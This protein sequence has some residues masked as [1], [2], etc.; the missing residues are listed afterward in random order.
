MSEVVV[1]KQ[2]DLANRK[3]TDEEQVEMDRRIAEESGI[4]EGD[5]NL[6]LWDEERESAAKQGKETEEEE[7]P[8]G[9]PETPPEGEETEEEEESTEE[10][11]EEEEVKVSEE[12]TESSLSDKEALIKEREEALESIEDEAEKETAQAE[13][14][15]MKKVYDKEDE[16]YEET[17]KGEQDDLQALMKEHEIG[18]DDAQTIIDGEKAIVEKYSGDPKKMARAFRHI[19]SQYSRTK[20]IAEDA[21]MRN[22]Q[23]LLDGKLEIDPVQLVKNA[24]G[25]DVT[26]EDLVG[27]Y[28]EQYPKMTV[29]MEDDAVFELIHKDMRSEVKRIAQDKKRQRKETALRKRETLIRSIPRSARKYDKQIKSILDNCSDGQVARDTFN[30]DDIILNCKGTDFD[31]AVKEAEEK[32][33]KRGLENR[34]IV[35][36]K[37]SPTGGKKPAS[38][39]SKSSGLS[40]SEKKEAEKMYE[41]DDIPVKDKYKHYKD[42]L[43]HRKKFDETNK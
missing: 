3:P 37:G 38:K 23:A 19:Q 2:A 30:L 5:P 6:P 28:R 35:A 43:D 41:T 33:Y 10:E 4:R 29:D 9:E 20:A 13:L 14:D 11:E 21:E 34:K 12:F 26:K 22:E 40:D 8:E 24:T 16:A 42:V 36:E 31:Q 1:L 25:E 17:R 18:E 39:P 7:K 15:S 32:G 27:R